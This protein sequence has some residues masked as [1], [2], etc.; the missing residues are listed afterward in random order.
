MQLVSGSFLHI[1]L[2]LRYPRDNGQLYIY[3]GR[4]FMEKDQ[5]QQKAR[6][7]FRHFEELVLL[8]LGKKWMLFW[9]FLAFA[10]FPNKFVLFTR[11]SLWMKQFEKNLTFFVTKGVD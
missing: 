6:S 5:V 7:M 11:I 4:N 3:H 10:S 8:P 2:L 1:A 9:P